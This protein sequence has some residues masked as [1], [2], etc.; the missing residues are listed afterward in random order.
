MNDASICLIDNL[1]LDLLNLQQSQGLSK[2]KRRRHLMQETSQR[3]GPH[4]LWWGRPEEDEMKIEMKKTKDK[5]GRNRDV[6]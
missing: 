1:D 2:K 6:P 5:Q 3:Y 4:Q